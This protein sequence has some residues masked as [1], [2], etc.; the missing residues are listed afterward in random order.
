MHG[1]L[2]TGSIMASQPDEYGQADIRV[3]DPEFAFFGPMGFDI[4]LFIANLF[5][6]AAA[7]H[8]HAKDE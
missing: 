7:Q 8:A 1:D 6:N 5:L 3:I 4:G 2:H